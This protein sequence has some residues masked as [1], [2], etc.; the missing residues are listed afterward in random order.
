MK[1]YL[2]PVVC[3]TFLIIN[4]CCCKLPQSKIKVKE[5]IKTDK[6]WNSTVLP[7]YPKKKPQITVL[8]ITIP[9]KAELPMHEHPVINVGYMIKGKLT[10]ITEDG[11]TLQLNEGD[12]IVETVNTWHYGKNEGDESA[13]IVVVYVGTKD[14][15]LTVKKQANDIKENN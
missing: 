11:K 1:K 4:A 5:L 9:P 3:C 6:S 2:F 7:D 10:V 12:P 14:S 13:E 8:K 15:L